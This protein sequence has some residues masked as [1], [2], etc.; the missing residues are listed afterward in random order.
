M[1]LKPS[2][3]LSNRSGILNAKTRE[4]QEL[5]AEAQRKMAETRRA[6]LEGMRAAKEVKADL[7]WVDRKVRVL[8]GRVEKRYVTC[9]TRFLT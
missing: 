9:C 1:Q 5:Q 3:T 2:L 4:L 6:F 7:E 8:K